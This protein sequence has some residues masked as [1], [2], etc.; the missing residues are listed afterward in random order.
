VQRLP[1]AAGITASGLLALA[2]G[3]A[4]ATAQEAGDGF[5]AAD[6][7]YGPKNDLAEGETAEIWNPAMRKLMDGG[8]LIGGTVRATDPRTYCAMAAA[9]YDFIWTEKQH[10]A[11]D[12]EQAA[13]MWRTCPGPAAPGARVAMESE[14]EIQIATDMG[15]L[16]ISVP[17]VDTVEEAQRAIDWT[18]FPPMGK[19]SAGGGQ[20]P[21]DMW[22]DVPGGY[23]QTWNDNV[24]LILMIETLEGVE[25]AREIA[26][27][28]GVDA[29]FAASG[30]LGNFSGWEEGDPEYERLIDEIAAAAEEAGV[31]LCGP[32]RWAERDGFSC[33]QAGTEAANI[34]RGAE[35]ELQGAMAAW[36]ARTGE[37]GEPEQ[38]AAVDPGTG[39]TLAASISADCG[40]IVYEADC[41]A[42]VEGALDEAEGLDEA[43][44]DAV[45]AALAQAIERNPNH[46]DQLREIAAE[47]PV[48]LGAL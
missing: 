43:E 39:A 8:P 41:F 33:F 12:W 45:R 48:D 47:A 3:A 2:L 34:R 4:G 15:A 10:E 22:R 42:A 36:N 25:N 14:R 20:G 26:A 46:A 9:G 24:V 31:A 37:G 29:I 28:D 27:L 11:I 16:V 18:Y 7:E 1:F 23:R 17:T 38:G 19:R 32:L 40:Q 13:R 5:R 21:G 44:L 30:D 35:V 6:F